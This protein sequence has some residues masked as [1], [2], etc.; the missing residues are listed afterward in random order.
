[1]Y[2]NLPLPSSSL[3]ESGVTSVSFGNMQ[4]NCKQHDIN[5]AFRHNVS[6]AD[7]SNINFF[8]S[9]A[10]HKNASPY[11]LQDTLVCHLCQFLEF[12]ASSKL[13]TISFRIWWK[14]KPVSVHKKLNSI[15]TN[16]KVA[17]SIPD[18]VI[19]IFHWHNPFGR[20]MALG[21][22]QP[23]TEMCTRNIS[24]GVKPAGA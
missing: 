3:Q 11:A 22:T 15:S 24:W 4:L 16:W 17:A 20:T 6:F 19:G 9:K 21:S 5:V 7:T 1:M 13:G 14:F 8:V 2:G 18:D 12:S 10:S 23:L